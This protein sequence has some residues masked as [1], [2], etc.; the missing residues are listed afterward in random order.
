[1]CQAAHS[2]LFS[3]LGLDLKQAPSSPLVTEIADSVAL[4]TC[5]QFHYALTFLERLAFL[6]DELGIMNYER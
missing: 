3:D 6:K 5:A 4:P 1:M 2:L